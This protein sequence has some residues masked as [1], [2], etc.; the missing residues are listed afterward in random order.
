MTN[1]V[2][3]YL[4][5]GLNFRTS[6]FREIIETKPDVDW[7]EV[8]TENYLVPGGKPHRLLEQIRHHYPITMHGVS[9]SLGG[10]DPLDKTY[11]HDV[12]Q[13]IDTYQPKWV[14]DHLCWTGVHHINSHDLLPLPYTEENLKHICS[15]ISEVQDYLGQKILIENVSSYVQFEHS[16]MSEWE[17]LT[18]VANQ[19]D[20]LLLLDINNVYVSAINHHFNPM[21]YLESIPA[22]RV[23]QHHLAGHLNC[24]DYIIDTHDAPI[25]LP[26]W[27]LYKKA[28]TLFG[29]VSTLIE[30][31]GVAPPLSD[32]LQEL[33]IAREI[34]TTK[35]NES[36]LVCQMAGY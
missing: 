29:P 16:E 7:F 36:E 24:D 26:V 31:D 23:Q 17:F 8:I 1:K 35:S 12:K 22:E 13:L 25:A 5:F 9:L 11:L 32:L 19:A 27:D 10:C 33:A 20:C 6:H 2:L 30:R 34:A 4:G 21:T 14:S 3:P 15:R 28:L 18:E